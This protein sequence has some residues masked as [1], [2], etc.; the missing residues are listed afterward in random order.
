MSFGGRGGIEEAKEDV[1]D[2]EGAVEDKDAMEGE[3]TVEDEDAVAPFNVGVCSSTSI[4]E[5]LFAIVEASFTEEEEAKV[6][7]GR[8]EEEGAP[9]EATSDRGEPRGG[10]ED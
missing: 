7:S 6:K 10:E 4:V 8:D 5:V 3:D 1:V 9:M 2:D